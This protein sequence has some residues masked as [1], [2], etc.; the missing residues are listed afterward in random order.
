MNELQAAYQASRSELSAK[1]A[2]RRAVA[3]ELIRAGKYL[4]VYDY[5]TYCPVTDGVLGVGFAFA[6]ADARWEADRRAEM[7]ARIDEEVSHI[8]VW[9]FKENR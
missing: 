9:P 4:I 5:T 6:V 3:D 2:E 1:N 8:R 7:L